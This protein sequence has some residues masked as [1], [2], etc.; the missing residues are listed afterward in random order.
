MRNKRT[1]FAFVASA[2]IVCSIASTALCQE[3]P[4]IAVQSEYVKTVPY[5]SENLRDPFEAYIRK[6]EVPL[7]VTQ[8]IA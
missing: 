7:P 1:G 5:T 8:L 4:A 2:I 3:E 6:E